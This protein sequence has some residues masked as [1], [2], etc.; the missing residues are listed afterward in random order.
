MTRDE[1]LRRL[2]YAPDWC[3]A[4]VIDEAL[5]EEQIRT[6]DT[7]SPE[8]FRW[9]MWRAF[10]SRELRGNQLTDARLE[11][12]LA[13]DLAEASAPPP[14]VNHSIAF[15]LAKYAPLSRAQI[16]R[17]CAHPIR[18]SRRAFERHLLERAIAY[19]KTNGAR[20]ERPRA[21]QIRRASVSRD[22]SEILRD[23]ECSPL[24]SI[25]DLSSAWD[26]PVAE[27]LAAGAFL[28]GELDAAATDAA[29]GPVRRRHE[30][31]WSYALRIAD[32]VERDHI[33]PD[34]VATIRA[35][36]VRFASS[37]RRVERLS[38][39]QALLVAERIGQLGDQACEPGVLSRLLET[40]RAAR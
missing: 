25:F 22:P 11:Q 12:L 39:S 33:D 8:H 20:P 30:P 18:G 34:L 3:E 36:L 14:H 32:A 4:G 16:E 7:D 10:A 31:G 17:V 15:D 21:M 1:A 5:L 27:L 37:L 38:I 35:S 24:E 9:T 2:A 40:A 26:A 23:L 29:L 19:E 28:R 6:A 13:L